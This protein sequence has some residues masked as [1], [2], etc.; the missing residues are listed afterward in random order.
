MANSNTPGG[1]CP[2]PGVQEPG[3]ARP[4]IDAVIGGDIPAVTTNV[5]S[6]GAEGREEQ[7]GPS[8]LMLQSAVRGWL[9]RSWVKGWQERQRQ[10]QAAKH[11]MLSRRRPSRKT[12]DA[13]LFECL[14][15][16]RTRWLA[17]SC[18]CC[19]PLVVRCLRDEEEEVRAAALHALRRLPQREL[20]KHHKAVGRLAEL[21]WGGA[22][23]SFRQALAA[24]ASL[25]RCRTSETS[26]Q[27]S[28]EELDHIMEL[29]ELVCA[30]QWNPERQQQHNEDCTYGSGY[31]RR[32]GMM[33]G[34][35]CRVVVPILREWQGHQD[36]CDA[37]LGQFG[38]S[39]GPFS[40]I[41]ER[42]I[43]GEPMSRTRTPKGLLQLAVSFPCSIGALRSLRSLVSFDVWGATF[44]P[45]PLVFAATYSD[46]RC[47]RFVL[48]RSS[49]CATERDCKHL[50]RGAAMLAVSRNP[51]PEVGRFLLA[52]LPP[53]EEGASSAEEAEE[54]RWEERWREGQ[55]CYLWEACATWQQAAINLIENAQA[56]DRSVRTRVTI[57]LDMG[58]LHPA[59]LLRATIRRA[60]SLSHS[61]TSDGLGMS[62]FELLFGLI[63][64]LDPDIHLSH[65]TIVTLVRLC[66]CAPSKRLLSS[67]TFCAPRP[68][69]VDPT[70]KWNRVADVFKAYRDKCSGCRYPP[71]P[72][73]E[74]G[75]A[76]SL[77]GGELCTS[78]FSVPS[79]ST[80]PPMWEDGGWKWENSLGQSRIDAPWRRGGVCCFRNPLVAT[81]I[82]GHGVDERPCSETALQ[83]GMALLES[84]PSPPLECSAAPKLRCGCGM[85]WCDCIEVSVSQLN[86]W[87]VD[88]NFDCT[89]SSGKMPA[90]ATVLWLWHAWLTDSIE[91]LKET[92]AAEEADGAA[93]A[94]HALSWAPSLSGA[95]S[96]LV[97][98]GATLSS[99]GAPIATPAPPDDRDGG[100]KPGG[101][102]LAALVGEREERRLFNSQVQTE[103]DCLPSS[104]P[105]ASPDAPLAH[106]GFSGRAF[107]RRQQGFRFRQGGTMPVTASVSALAAATRSCVLSPKADGLRATVSGDELSPPL[108]YDVIDAELMADGTYILFGVPSGEDWL[109]QQQELL[110]LE[111]ALRPSAAADQ[112]S[113]WAL[114]EHLVPGS[115]HDA[116]RLLRAPP[117][118]TFEN[119]G[120]IVWDRATG[121][122]LKVKPDVLKTLDLQWDAPH[123]GESG[124]WLTREGSEYPNALHPPS[125][126][127]AAS[128]SAGLVSE[129]SAAARQPRHREVWRHTW[130]AELGCW[131][132]S[133]PRPDKRQPNATCV[134]H[135]LSRDHQQ[136]WTAEGILR[137][138]GGVDGGQAW[139]GNTAV[140]GGGQVGV[141]VRR[142]APPS[143]FRVRHDALNLGCGFDR[144]G[145]TQADADPA[146]L[147]PNGVLL[148]LDRPWCAAEQLKT[149]DVGVWRR[150]NL[151][152]LTPLARPHSQILLSLVVNRLTT[153]TWIG[154]CSRCATSGTELLLSFLDAD[155]LL[156]LLPLALGG[157]CFVRLESPTSV[158]MR[159]PFAS[160]P[161][162]IT[163]RLVSAACLTVQLGE[164]GWCLEQV[165]HGGPPVAVAVTTESGSGL[166]APAPPA[167][168]GMDA[169][170]ACY[171]WMRLRKG[172]GKTG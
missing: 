153:D 143:W 140:S 137:G 68:S 35:L 124:R 117:E 51:R 158:R 76:F 116:L 34:D 2:P 41:L 94:R 65:E 38:S 36:R 43:Q 75:V 142:L 21:F 7:C 164:H 33:M 109:A 8:L 56:T 107:R 172:E 161:E 45:G 108:P 57:L 40:H 66:D 25:L 79:E 46:L 74:G 167:R 130:D 90:G 114:K 112:S 139:Y 55:P 71:G 61:P 128:G 60:I 63:L 78:G 99:A 59:R 168:D 136:P 122:T 118:T 157:S 105:E 15:A 151:L 62:R 20:A 159:L 148:D 6:K 92:D 12:E 89:L 73:Q 119:D 22:R 42:I 85:D 132:P 156:P 170:D 47:V 135:R 100:S 83:I 102:L 37:D 30:L 149:F 110:E 13:A 49:E 70:A 97:W 53:E 27:R 152:E 64:P 39:F 19:A 96:T 133:E 138:L 18:R 103:L 123:G 3:G 44:R 120:W 28:M 93:D 162:P 32:K 9:V 95:I 101:E 154:E 31:A 91:W 106:T 98:H 87:G 17:R 150:R 146:T 4:P 26:G 166:P 80:S 141:V 126:G 84:R 11:R 24:W 10:V 54:E 14:K 81:L 67:L 125:R 113:N 147:G 165:E 1:L 77:R 86:A 144:S 111:R 52:M 104:K 171:V 29:D 127:V 5:S 115:R 169:Y 16:C 58:L 48:S 82:D 23:R 129:A 160:H 72:H 69:L 134:A 145:G 88:L 50:L 155:R 121:A 131:R 163:E